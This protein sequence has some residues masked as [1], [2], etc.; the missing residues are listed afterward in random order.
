MNYLIKFLKIFLV[1]IIVSAICILLFFVHRDISLDDLKLK[2]TNK[3]SSFVSIKGMDVHFRDEGSKTDTIPIILIHGTGSSLHTFDFWTNKLKYSKRVIRFDLPAY[4]L[5]G[6]FVDRDYSISN[7]TS[8]LKEFL[9]TLD[10]KQC[11][12]AGNSLGGEIAWNFALEHPQ[13][14]KKLIL[15]DAG[16]FPLVSKS[17][18]IAFRL[19]QIPVINKLFSFITPLFVVRSSVEDVYFNKLKVTG[20]VY[21]WPEVASRS[22]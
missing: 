9:E 3:H 22:S 2:Y 7:Y 13:M 19:A 18:P 4:G 21:T 5:T 11:T 6:P 15:I 14:V 10:I 1:L 17:V 20:V 16:G 8:F 12:I